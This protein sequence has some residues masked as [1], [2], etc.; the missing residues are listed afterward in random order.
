MTSRLNVPTSG[1]APYVRPRDAATLILLRGGVSNPE[2]LMGRRSQAMAFMPGLYVF[3]GGRLER[4]DFT[5]QRIGR[6]HTADEKRLVGGMGSRGNRARA[7]ALV[8]SA[9]RET[10][11]ETGLLLGRSAEPAKRRRPAPHWRPFAEHRVAP[12]LAGVRYLARAITPPGRV[13]RFD[14]RFFVATEDMIA[15]G[16]KPVASPDEELEEVAWVRL[17]DAY[18]LK[19]PPITGVV[20]DILAQRLKDDPELTDAPPVPFYRVVNRS[21]IDT[22]E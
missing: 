1:E 5:A 18:N 8:M 10:H 21:F 6:L 12:D 22:P 19:I 3:P 7:E 17:S 16:G 11:E 20:L 2:I 4:A 13:R 14:T 15:N 9:I